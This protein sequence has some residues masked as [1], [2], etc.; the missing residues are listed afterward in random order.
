MLPRI[1]H[2]TAFADFVFTDLELRLDEQDY[3]G[4]WRQQGDEGG[5]QQAQ[6]DERG[7]HRQEAHAFR[8]VVRRQVAGVGAFA[9]DDARVVAQPPVQLAVAHVHGVDAPGAGL[10]ETI[11]KA[12]RGS[13]DVEGDGILY[14]TTKRRKTRC[15]FLA[16]AADVRARGAQQPH[17]RLDCHPRS[18][19]RQ[20]LAVHGDL[21]RQDQCLRLR[22]TRRQLS[23]PDQEVESFP[24][25]GHA[26]LA[27]TLRLT[28]KRASC[29]SRSAP[30]SKSPR[31]ASASFSNAVACWREVSMPSRAG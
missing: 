25:G 5:K 6:R 11:G 3:L 20:A 8:E 14:P 15:Q 10:Q 22:P 13:A 9:Y 23:L 1:A 18:A 4:L 21:A 27:Q 28:M 17:I 7:V 29:R 2:H 19:L 16:A 30:R 26:R 31:A 24:F 12:A